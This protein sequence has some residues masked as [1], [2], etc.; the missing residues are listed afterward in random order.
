MYAAGAV[1][2]ADEVSR[3]GSEVWWGQKYVDRTTRGDPGI[4]GPVDSTE[5]ELCGAGK[6]S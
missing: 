1:S 6:I 5:A 2:E 3:R 4:P